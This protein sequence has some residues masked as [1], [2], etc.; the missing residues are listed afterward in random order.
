MGQPSKTP[1]DGLWWETISVGSGGWG[2][3]ARSA[4]PHL[5]EDLLGLF[6]CSG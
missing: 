6:G 2:G 4:K 1:G 3:K 5:I